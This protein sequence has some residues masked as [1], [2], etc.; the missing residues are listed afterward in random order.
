MDE[1]R[2]KIVFAAHFRF[3]R[4]GIK[5]LNMDYIA[6]DCNVSRKTLDRYFKRQQLLEAVINHILEAH[7]QSLIAIEI[8][9]L[10]PLE[11]LERLLLLMEVLSSGLSAVLLRD[12]RRYYHE[13]WLLLDRFITGSVKRAFRSN[14]NKG[15]TSGL[16]RLNIDVEVLTDVYVATVLNLVENQSP[17]SQM[18]AKNSKLK[19]FND[20]F[21]AGVV[22]KG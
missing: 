11:E 9:R 2:N 5:W 18:N 15:I 7:E 21:F 22:A 3:L 8:D 17:G 14:L 12:L 20:I 16:Y 10:E 1:L 6:L 13:N 4:D 19:V